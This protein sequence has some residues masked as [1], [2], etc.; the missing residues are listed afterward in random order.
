MDLYQI[1][2]NYTPGDK[3]G[4]ASGVICFTKAYIERNMKKSSCLKPKGLSHDF[5]YEALSS[6]LLPSLFKLYPWG[7]K[8][9]HPVGHMLYIGL[10]REKHEKFFL[11][12]TIRPRD[13]VFGM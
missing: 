3:N 12:E 4:T 7:Q 13:M 6:G 1:C 10:N 8:W 2:S 9:P 11:A 5:W